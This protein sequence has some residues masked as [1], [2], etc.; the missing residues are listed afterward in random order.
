MTSNAISVLTWNVW[1]RYG[2]WRERQAAIIETL[3]A[4]NADVV[5][6]QE[7]WG[8]TAKP[9]QA[10][11]IA[12]ALG[13]D[14]VRSPQNWEDGLS[15]GNAIL[16]RFPI[17]QH[18]SIELTKDPVRPFTRT[19]I[20][21]ELVVDDH[22]VRVFNTHLEWFYD[23]SLLRQKQL[24]EVCRLVARTRR[25]PMN[26]FPPILCGDFNCDSDSDEVRRLVGKAAPHEPGLV[27]TDAWASAR[28]GL[29][30]ST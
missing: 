28:P 4:E 7:V 14:V 2:P 5:C 17:K 8:E 6:L 9:D 13:Y 27:F 18:E 24:G 15:F 23:A 11:L 1:W 26:E 19:V 16:S 20:L 3:R 12:E 25:D 10:Q 30:G 29:D 21:A 22:L